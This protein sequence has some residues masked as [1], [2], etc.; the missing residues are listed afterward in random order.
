MS[1]EALSTPTVIDLSTNEI[2]QSTVAELIVKDPLFIISSEYTGNVYD[3]GFHADWNSQKIGMVFD[4]TDQ[5]WKLFSNATG[6]TALNMDFTAITYAPLACGDI[7]MT[8]N[9]VTQITSIT[10]G[11]TL[12]FRS[13]TLITYTAT[14]GTG[15]GAES[16]TFTNSFITAN[17]SILTSITS[18]GGTGAPSVM[19]SAKATGSCTVTILNASS[20]AN[21]NAS[22]QISFWVMGDY[23]P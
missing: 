5:I 13:G 8:Q 19:V 7:N 1:D 11:V 22:V 21:L 4:A 9:T 12:N 23:T 3:V 15:G 18:Y 20:G 14:S 17:S 16:F 2:K 10:T 6:A